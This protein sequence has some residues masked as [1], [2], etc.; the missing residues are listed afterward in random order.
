[1]K[2]SVV[3]PRPQNPGPMVNQVWHNRDLKAANAEQRS[4]FC[5]ASLVVTLQYGLHI[6]EQNVTA[7]CIE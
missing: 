4:K 7:Q 6:L 1:M 2:R 3:Q 5:S